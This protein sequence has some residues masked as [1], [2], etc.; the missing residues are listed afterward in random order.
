MEGKKK[1]LSYLK[2]AISEKKNYLH[3]KYISNFS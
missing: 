3:L 2:I 1:Y